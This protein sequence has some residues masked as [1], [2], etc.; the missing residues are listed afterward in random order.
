M[1]SKLAAIVTALALGWSQDPGAGDQGPEPLA[2]G[3]RGLP[4]RVPARPRQSSRQQDRVVVLHRQRQGRRRTPLRLPGHL[5]PR[6][7][8]SRAGQSVEVGDSRSL[9]DAS[10]DQRRHRAALSLRE[11]LS[12]G[13][14][15]LAGATSDRYQ[16]WN[17]DWMAGIREPGSFAPSA[18][19]DKAGSRE[20]VLRATS[21]Q[22]GL[23]LTLGE[24][25]RAGDQRQSTASARRARSPAMP[26]TTTR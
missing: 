6:R 24:G 10:R 25:K 18:S 11:K 13:G 5:L 21:A 15:G 20:H 16:V 12:R 23:D 7:H 2:T 19:A 22:A 9:H 8:R 3:D 14:P 1:M 17:D 26:R 4:V